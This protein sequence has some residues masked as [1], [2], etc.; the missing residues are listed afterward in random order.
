MAEFRQ[1]D[2]VRLLEEAQD[3]GGV[4]MTHYDEALVPGAVVT[5]VGLDLYDPFKSVQINSG[6]PGADDWYVLAKYLEPIKQPQV[7]VNKKTVT[8]E[9]VDT[10]TITLTAE[11]ARELSDALYESNL[12]LDERTEDLYNELE[13][14]LNA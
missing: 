9:V 2:K 5:V 12:E 10:I 4:A 8:T 3:S 7:T 13:E 11:Q 6:A 14:A 1:G